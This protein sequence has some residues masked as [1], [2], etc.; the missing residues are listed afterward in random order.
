MSATSSPTV[1]ALDIATEVCSVALARGDRVHEVAETVGQR[2]SARL[3]PMVD[4]LLREQRLALAD[5]AA[6]AFGAGPG[7]FTGLRIACAVA[8]GLAWASDR[9]VAPVG[10]LEAI[11]WHARTLVPD[12]QRVAAVIDARMNE[13]YVAVFDVRGEAPVELA[14]PALV[15]AAALAPALAALAPDVLAG[16]GVAAFAP[17]LAAL[18]GPLRLP[19]ARATAGTIARLA[20]RAV[21]AGRTLAPAQAAPLY[22]RDQ[23]ALTSGER[24]ARRAAATP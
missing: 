20:Q 22:V 9:P 10:N 13:A 24:A 16:E 18:T 23:V 8:Q 19:P 14:A 15:A 11:A 3:L 12:A 2:H 4:A 6:I 7:S 5:C 1:L 21:A 17:Q